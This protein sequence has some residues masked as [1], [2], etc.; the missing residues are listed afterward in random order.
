MMGE[1]NPDPVQYHV[2]LS[3]LKQTFQFPF[4]FTINLDEPIPSQE[5]RW[6]IRAYN[7]R[8]NKQVDIKASRSFTINFCPFCGQLLLPGQAAP[9]PGVAVIRLDETAEGENE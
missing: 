4:V 7:L 5:P 3:N 8:P 2:C 6:L 1:P 9:I